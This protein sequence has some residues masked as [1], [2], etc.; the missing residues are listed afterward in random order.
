MSANGIT[1]R[2]AIALAA[3]AAV[4][5]RSGRAAAAGLVTTVRGRAT[6]TR[7]GATID[8]HQGAA[9]EVGDALRTHAG[10]R[11]L[12]TLVDGSTLA[13]GEL[14][15]LVLTTAD[16]QPQGGAGL[17]FDLLDGIVRAVLGPARP[18]VFAVRGRVAVAA[19]RSTDFIVETTARQTDVFVA[20]GEVA[21]S[22]VYG[23][24]EAVLAAGDGID[25]VRGEPLRPV[26]RWGQR[27]IDDVL[28]RTAVV[29]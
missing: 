13:L 5:P 11:L 2:G 21:V 28:A 29:G 20:A 3:A 26:V 16:A 7:A 12:V 18:D 14:S 27:R 25:V 15:Q 23:P 8:L 1:R 9:V 24:G 10:A 4:L 17:V 19:A 6:A 22:E